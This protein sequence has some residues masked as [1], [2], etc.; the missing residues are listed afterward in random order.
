MAYQLWHFPDSGKRDRF[1][2]AARRTTTGYPL[3]EHAGS[4]ATAA[5]RSVR[6][7]LMHLPELQVYCTKNAWK[8]VLYRALHPPAAAASPDRSQA[9][10]FLTRKASVIRDD[11][12]LG[13]A[14]ARCA[15]A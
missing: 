5:G 4:A 12:L 15:A 10:R 6:L 7:H 11:Q 2:F 3:V 13:H 9:N 8:P 1:F 14:Q